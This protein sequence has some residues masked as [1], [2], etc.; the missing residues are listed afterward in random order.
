MECILRVSAGDFDVDRFVSRYP[1]LRPYAVWHAGEPTFR[2]RKHSDSGFILVIGEA[3]VWSDLWKRAVRAMAKL[4]PVLAGA[5]RAGAEMNLD[6]ALF[7]GSVPFTSSAL[8][9]ASDL[10]FLAKLGVS[11]AVSAYPVSDDADDSNGG[12]R[13]PSATARKQKVQAT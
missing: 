2:K 6:F 4:R 7:V 5:R 11:L 13:R 9:S 1:A 12:R 10:T 8:F 3:Q